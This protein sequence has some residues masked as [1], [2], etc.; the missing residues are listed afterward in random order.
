[1]VSNRFVIFP[2]YL[3]ADVSPKRTILIFPTNKVKR[4][5]SL[6]TMSKYFCK[7]IEYGILG[8]GSQI[9]TNQN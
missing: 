6:L 2:P 8:E 9:S 5:K 7:S 1:M 4:L 3:R